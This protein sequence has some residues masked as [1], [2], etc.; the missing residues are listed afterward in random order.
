MSLLCGLPDW[1]RGLSPLL[2]DLSWSDRCSVLVL[3]TSSTLL[4]LYTYRGTHTH[5]DQPRRA[6][7][8]SPVSPAVPT[9]AS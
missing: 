5:Q 7:G 1:P 2:R 8:V 6:L 4:A 9:L 3:V